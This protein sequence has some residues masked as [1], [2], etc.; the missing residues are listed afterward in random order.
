MHLICSLYWKFCS[1]WFFVKDSKHFMW[2]GKL[3][4]S[5]IIPLKWILAQVVNI[6][7]LP[8][9][10]TKSTTFIVGIRV[11]ENSRY[12]PFPQFCSRWIWDSKLISNFLRLSFSATSTRPLNSS[13]VK[14]FPFFTDREA[15]SWGLSTPQS[16]SKDYV[17]KRNAKWFK[18][19]G[20][21]LLYVHIS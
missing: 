4:L 7:R 8:Y 12:I 10:L 2:R 21:F 15:S 5:S 17:F 20:T 9:T 3:A 18:S 1:Y 19:L 6:N 11:H 16:L 13:D 14:F